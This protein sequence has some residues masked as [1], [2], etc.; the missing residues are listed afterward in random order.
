MSEEKRPDYKDMDWRPLIEARTKQWAQ[1]WQDIA[2]EGLR[3]EPLWQNEA[4][5]PGYEAAHGQPI[6]RLALLPVQREK[7]G[8]I[9]VTP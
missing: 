5:V 6:P 4:E 1:M 8:V 7:R 3:V 9:I 2:R